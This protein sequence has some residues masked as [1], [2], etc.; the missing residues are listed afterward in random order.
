MSGPSGRGLRRT[1]AVPRDA[2]QEG[3]SGT[4]SPRSTEIDYQPAHRDTCVNA[5]HRCGSCNQM[6]TH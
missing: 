3:N 5:E 2:A 6:A 1:A 4:S